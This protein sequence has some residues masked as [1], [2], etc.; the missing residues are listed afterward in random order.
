MKIKLPLY[1]FGLAALVLFIAPLPAS[2]NLNDLL[3]MSEKADQADKQDFQGALDSANDCTRT[4]NFSCSEE[5]L[6]KAAKLASD[7]KDRQALNSATQ[8]L[9]AEQQ[10]VKEEALAKAERERQIQL[11]ENR[12]REEEDRAEQRRRE[13]EE[14]NRSSGSSGGGWGAAFAQAMPGIIQSMNQVAE[15]DMINRQRSQELIRQA[16]DERRAQEE[17]A[18]RAQE[19]AAADRREEERASQRTA[20]DRRAQEQR[21]ADDQRAQNERAAREQQAR[22]ER[23][24]EARRAQEA[25]RQ[26]QAQIIR[27]QASAYNP[28]SLAQNTVNSGAGNSASTTRKTG[29]SAQNCVRAS[30]S[31]ETLTFQNSCGEHVFVIWCGDLKYSKKKCGD[32]G[33]YYNMSANIETGGET[34][35]QI[36]GQY[37]Y[38]A[39]KGGISFGNDGNYRETSNGGVEC[40]KR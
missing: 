23:A 10:R 36:S 38:A 24:A 34:T 1:A 18:R 26:R 5:L 8:N 25:E 3:E 2:A 35:A 13:E 6:R 37:R 4:R 15:Q 19:R 32:N 28:P 9:H 14:S 40:L 31:G 20:Y 29:E 33:M 12:R 11:A 21:A 16:Q 22:E 39:C 7:N 27:N 30:V 17:A